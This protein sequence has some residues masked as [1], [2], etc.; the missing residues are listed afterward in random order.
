MGKKE[1]K[2]KKRK[3]GG[4]EG[5]NGKKGGKGGRERGG[6]GK[7]YKHTYAYSEEAFI[8]SQTA[9]L[10]CTSE[11]GGI[12]QLFLGSMSDTRVLQ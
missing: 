8:F 6:K 9:I 2:G 11:L 12:V 1:K 3:K 5:K 10:T 4:K 7:R